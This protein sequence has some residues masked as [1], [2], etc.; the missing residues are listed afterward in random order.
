MVGSGRADWLRSPPFDAAMVIGVLGL[1][2]AMGAVAAASP[3]LFLSVLAI[4]IW[5]LAYPHFTST[6]PMIAFDR[7]TAKKHWFLLI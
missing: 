3:A 1:A 6:Y 2:L 4:D 7:R 5:I